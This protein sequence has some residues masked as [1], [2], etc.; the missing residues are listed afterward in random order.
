LL[1][2]GD[3]NGDG[4][5]DLALGSFATGMIRILLS[6][7]DGTFQA[8][9]SV[10]GTASLTAMCAGDWNGD[11]KTDLALLD[12]NSSSLVVLLSRGD[13]N[14]DSTPVLSI[15]HNSVNACLSA[16]FNGDG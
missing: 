5:T 13:G 12:R 11:H 3:F 2:V 6:H 1:V 16:D 15:S 9:A 4:H 10:P 7:G 8:T 14:F